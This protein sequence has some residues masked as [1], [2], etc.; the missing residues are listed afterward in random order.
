MTIS[1]FYALLKKVLRSEKPDQIVE[2]QYLLNVVWNYQATVKT[3]T[4]DNINRSME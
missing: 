1:L 2:R 4:I 3:R